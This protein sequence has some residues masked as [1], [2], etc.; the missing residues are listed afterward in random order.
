[1]F[2]GT[3]ESWSE[4]SREQAGSDY[5]SH[6]GRVHGRKINDMSRLPFFTLRPLLFA[7][8]FIHLQCHM[9]FPHLDSTVPPFSLLLSTHSNWFQ[10]LVDFLNSLWLNQTF[11]LS[12]IK[13]RD[14][15][16]SSGS[17]WRNVI[18]FNTCLKKQNK[19]YNSTTMLVVIY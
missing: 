18:R 8:V 4:T 2:K 6:H 9:M 7:L 15:K 19:E 17:G 3:A 13:M 16:T 1:M 11:L 5:W 10:P 12:Q 14:I